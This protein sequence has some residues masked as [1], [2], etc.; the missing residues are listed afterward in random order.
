MVSSEGTGWPRRADGSWLADAV[1]MLEGCAAQGE[2][3]FFRAIGVLQQTRQGRVVEAGA[4][5]T[6]VCSCGGAAV[7]DGRAAQQDRIAEYWGAV[8]PRLVWDRV[9]YRYLF[10]LYIA[11]VT[12]HHRDQVPVGY[13]TFARGLLVALRGGS[14]YGFVP[15]GESDSIGDHNKFRPGRFMDAPEMLSVDYDLVGWINERAPVDEPLRRAVMPEAKK[16]SKYGGL[17]REVR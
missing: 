9:P 8:G 16:K 17:L 13:Q 3:E 6:P 7:T 5:P 11:W 14:T 1:R 15:G 10:D 2:D 12:K 4:L